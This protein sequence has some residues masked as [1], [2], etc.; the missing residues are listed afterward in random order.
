MVEGSPTI[1]GALTCT[2]RLVIIGPGYF[3]GENPNSNSI[4]TSARIGGFCTFNS[5]SANSYIIGM[6]VI[7]GYGFRLYTSNI[8]V[9][10]CKGEV[11]FNGS[12]GNTISNCK[13]VG[14]YCSE[15]TCFSS[16]YNANASVTNCII[17]RD[18][19][20]INYLNY[21]HNVLVGSSAWNISAGT[22]RSNILVDATVSANITSSTIQNNLAQNGQ[23]GTTNGNINYNPANLFVGGASS[24]GRYQIKSASPYLNAGHNGT[25]PG[26]FGGTD[27]YRLSGTPT[28]P[29][30]YELTVPGTGSTSQG[31]SISVK[32]RNAN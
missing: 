8:Y 6:E 13:V 4:V 3:L 28:V 20:G 17:L 27:S 10:R 19:S 9:I 22:F 29:V 23:F 2:K 21:E 14:S 25:Q 31:L 7:S 5:G 30:I 15:I 16:Q 18:A 32:I 11:S 12:P 24:D 26:I 1:Y